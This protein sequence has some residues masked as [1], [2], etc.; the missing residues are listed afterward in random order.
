MNE[1]LEDLP[2]LQQ[3]LEAR[4][5]RNVSRASSEGKSS[6]SRFQEF[7]TDAYGDILFEGHSEDALLH[8]PSQYLRLSDDSD[9]RDVLA[10]LTEH[11]QVLD[12]MSQ[13]GRCQMV[14][15]LLGMQEN[16]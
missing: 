6:S 3:Y 14:I 15:S 9:M 11:W 7:V 4:K 13:K 12:A 1:T 2:E 5:V 16:K 10:L 8:I